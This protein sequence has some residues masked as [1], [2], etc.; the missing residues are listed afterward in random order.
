MSADTLIR[1]YFNAFNERRFAQG[2]ALFASESRFAWI[3]F[4]DPRQGED[5]YRDF[6]ER[7]A[8]AFPNAQLR[9]EHVE[10]RGDRG[11][12]VRVLVTGTHAGS[13]ELG[14]YRFE[15]T[16]ATIAVRARQV[17]EFEGE[18][19]VYTSLSMDTQELMRQLTTLDTRALDAQLERIVRLQSALREAGTDTQRVRDVADQLGREIDVA[20]HMLRPYYHR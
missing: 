19:I 11:C 20:R 3:P 8:G 12:E 15:P 13:L 2:A 16:Q 1:H 6:I 4:G 14:I 7:W 9:I 10:Q 18:Q 5:G 17:I